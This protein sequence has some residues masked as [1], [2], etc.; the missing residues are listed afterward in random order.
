MTHVNRLATIKRAYG[1]DHELTDPHTADGVKVARGIYEA[2]EAIVCPETAL[3]VKFEAT[4]HE[5]VREASAP[6]PAALESLENLPQRIRVVPNNATTVEDIVKE[7]L[8]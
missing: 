6:R 5:A 7:A 3:A 4:I 8:A 1:Q 2:G